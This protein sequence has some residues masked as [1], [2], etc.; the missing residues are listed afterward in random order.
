MHGRPP[1]CSGSTVIRSAT[2]G[3]AR[4]YGSARVDR[5]ALDQDVLEQAASGVAGAG[6][7][8]DRTDARGRVA[9]ASCDAG[10]RQDF[11]QSL[12]VGHVSPAPGTRASLASARASR[13]ASVASSPRSRCRRFPH[14]S[15]RECERPTVRR[16]GAPRCRRLQATSDPRVQSRRTRRNTQRRSAAS[17]TRTWLESGSVERLS[18]ARS[19]RSRPRRS[20]AGGRSPLA[21]RPRCDRPRPGPRGADR[22]RCTGRR[23]GGARI[24]SRWS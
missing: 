11:K 15:A 16:H 4:I 13:W 1:H 22:R 24:R 18:P 20:R 17:A 5:H 3:I 7:D 23:A 9:S 19:S 10:L 14:R 6:R 8:G 2:S 21:V 12:D